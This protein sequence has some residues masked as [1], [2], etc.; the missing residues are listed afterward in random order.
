MSYDLTPLLTTIAASSASFVAI[1]GGFIASKMISISSERENVLAKIHE[2]EQQQA[3]KQGEFLRLQTALFEGQSLDFISGNI[4]ALVKRENLENVYREDI[5]QSISKKDL[6]P[7]WNRA[8]NL[9]GELFNSFEKKEDLN[10]D[11][12][13]VPLAKKYSQDHFAYSVFKELMDWVAKQQTKPSAST[14]FNRIKT[15]VPLNTKQIDELESDLKWLSFQHLQLVE[16]KK[17]LSKPRGMK[18]GLII[19]G[20]FSLGCIVLP[21][22]L[23]PL[24]TDNTCFYRMIKAIV[25]FLFCIGLSAIFL[26]LVYLLKWEDGKA[27]ERK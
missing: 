10:E 19:F 16:E 21:L 17:R 9:A 27:I 7:Y 25:L 18:A 6:L 22:M 15:Y 13:P 14:Y 26:Y 12:I 20:L 2:V 8:N 5:Q 11:K 23:S 24:S 3:F 1:L 4:N